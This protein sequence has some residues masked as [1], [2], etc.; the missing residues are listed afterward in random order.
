MKERKQKGEGPGLPGGGGGREPEAGPGSDP[1]DSGPFVLQ[2][3][4]VS[5]VQFL[6][7]R[8][9]FSFLFQCVFP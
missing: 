8:F 1:A 9:S 3:H 7:L 6:R 5:A 4:A 2:D